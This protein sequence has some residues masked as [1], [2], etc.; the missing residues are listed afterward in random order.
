MKLS[1]SNRTFKLSNLKLS[2]GP[3]QLHVSPSFVRRII[4]SKVSW[5]KLTK[6]LYQIERSI[7]PVKTIWSIKIMWKFNEHFLWFMII[8]IRIIDFWWEFHLT[9]H[10]FLNYQVGHVTN[11]FILSWMSKSEGV[12]VDCTLPRKEYKLKEVPYRSWITKKIEF[13]VF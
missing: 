11:S 8:R 13:S 2:N 5:P 1:K 10:D 12:F 6:K 3:F 7:P 9:N 4:L